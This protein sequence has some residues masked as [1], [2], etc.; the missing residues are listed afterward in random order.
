MLSEVSF[1]APSLNWWCN[2]SELGSLALAIW[3]DITDNLVSMHVV[4]CYLPEHSL[5]FIHSLHGLPQLRFRNPFYADVIA[6]TKIRPSTFERMISELLKTWPAIR[7]VWSRYC[8]EEIP[9]T[10]RDP[11]PKR[12]RHCTVP[13][14]TWRNAPTP[15]GLS[16][17]QGAGRD[18]L[19]SDLSHNKAKA[20]CSHR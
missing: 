16:R 19:R 9:P 11:Q 13:K 17:Q 4:A 20:G 18:P 3:I 12:D 7:W 14:W 5:V 6:S 8:K 2:D 10:K 15:Q 1:L